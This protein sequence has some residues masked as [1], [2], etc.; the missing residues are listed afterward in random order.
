[1]A[2]SGAR[3]LRIGVVALGLAFVLAI[4][5]GATGVL[6][7]QAQRTAAGASSTL[8]ILSGAVSLRPSGREFTAAADGAIL[9]AGDTVRT[10]TDGRAVVT[11]FEGTTVEMEPASELTIDVASA[12]PDGSTVLLMT[13]SI[14]KTWHVVT[15]LLSGNSKYEVRTPAS[16][17]SVRG[18]QFEV[19]VTTDATTVTTSEGRVATS[20][21]ANT[22]EVLVTPGLTTTTKI[23]EKPTA[24]QPAPEPVRRA[25]VTVADPNSLVVDPLGRA[26]GFK[27]GKLV[28]QT[29]G[30][31]VRIV[32]GQLVVTLPDPAD[33]VLS[34][35]AGRKD[36]D[37]A[38]ETT[39]EDRGVSAVSLKSTAKAHDDGVVGVK[40]HGENGSPL[41]VDTAKGDFAEP[42]VPELKGASSEAKSSESNSS[43]TKSA[44][45][46]STETKSTET[47]SSDTKSPDTKS[48]D[49]K[50]TDT[51]STE[52]KSSDTKSSD[53]TSS[54]GKSSDPKSTDTT[55]APT[56]SDPKSSD[57]KTSETPTVKTPEQVTGTIPDRIADKTNKATDRP[58]ATDKPA[59]KDR[60]SDPTTPPPTVAP[61]IPPPSPPPPSPP[62]PAPAIPSGFVPNIGFQ[63]PGTNGNERGS[64]KS[65]SKHKA[66]NDK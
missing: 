54:N 49:T 33:G 45:P 30:A 21:P 48:T 32:N 14:G 5:L 15:H 50:S 41:S 27:N 18:T 16:T 29:P 60:S 36:V 17:A 56:S 23:G 22:T 46:K 53:T 6:T 19:A 13:Q 3:Y 62:P 52:T 11:Y 34:A 20:D 26:N 38:V 28:I 39:L 65:D 57:A 51:K 59:D 12:E 4:A 44:E 40:I 24:P 37:T 64:G 47:K 61:A 58:A 7:P 10:G 31:S 55:T 35:H 42:K 1:M 66:D 63:L 25:I 8:T 2:G 43:D 9:S